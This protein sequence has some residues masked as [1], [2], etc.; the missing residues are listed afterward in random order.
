MTNIIAV[1]GPTA[2]G[3]TALSI[4]L[5]MRLGG[6]VV[7]C[8]S[9]QIYK[10]MDIGT[11][12]PTDEE[13]RGIPHHMIDVA[14]PTDDFSCADY[15]AMAKPIIDGISARGKAVIVCG[16]TGLYF[17]SLVRHPEMS[18]EGRNDGVRT[19]LTKYAESNGADALH[20]K[21]RAVDPEAADA[22][23]PANVRRVIRALEIYETTGIT[24][25]EW[26][27]RSKETAPDYSVTAFVLDYLDRDI[28]YS[29][30]DK[31]VDMMLDCGLESEVRALYE[32]G[33][34][35]EKSSAAQAIGYK[36]MREYLDGRMSLGEAADLIRQS[37][38]RYAKRQI[39]WFKRMDGAVRLH[40]DEYAPRIKT[41]A[42]LADEAIDRMT[43]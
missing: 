33:K 14:E 26:D 20:A 7:S 40:P 30:I 23:H 8:D 38:R 18:S 24:K 2:S 1:L 11:A 35:D 4:E 19:A 37:S 31:R 16:G 28:L 22:I 6:E 3:K 27:R 15:A 34:L 9:M 41:A 21:L 25:S 32:A 5:A 43:E 10:G 17:D 13:K 42:E 12:K 39:T 29:R 36:E